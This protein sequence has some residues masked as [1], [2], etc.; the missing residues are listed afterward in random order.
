[1]HLKSGHSSGGVDMAMVVWTWQWWP[2]HGGG[3][4][5]MAVVVWTWQWWSRYGSGDLD[6]AVVTQNPALKKW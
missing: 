5:D 3:G 4:L 6:M 1:M 2:G